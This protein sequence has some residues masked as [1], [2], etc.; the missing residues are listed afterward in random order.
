MRLDRP[1]KAGSPLLAGAL[2]IA[3]IVAATAVA[4]QSL[5]LQ[6]PRVFEPGV[7]SGPA[8]D[9]APTF[10]PDGRT[11]LFER[12]NGSWS[13]I[14][15]SH[16]IG[17]HWSKPAIAPFAGPS[18]DQQ[19]TLSPDGRYLIYASSRARP[20]STTPGAP[21]ELVTNLWRVERTPA[22]WSEPV[23][24]PD[25]VN[26]SKRVFKPSIAANGDIYFMSDEGAG[27]APKWRIYKAEFESGGYRRAISLPFSDGRFPDV[28][29]Y[30]APDQSYVVF[31]SKGRRLPNDDDHEHLYIV[32][33]NGVA[34]G[35]VKPLRY[36]G[37]ERGYDDGE[38]QVGL[39]GDTLYFTSGRSEPIHRSRTRAQ[40]LDDF[41]R[42]EAWDNGNNNVWMLSLAR[43]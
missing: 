8:N 36:A 41:A 34:W 35:P 6:T 25:E 14:L 2:S 22:G 39:D 18:S 11:L 10:T 28:D 24:L 15:V 3:G 20:S 12:S 5:P 29:P 1:G 7:I 42:L 26:I 32:R 13:T 27:G 30:V 37:D 19:P 21:L 4:A 43:G 33:R 38:A 31:S 16:R 9:G 17:E 40:M 23:R